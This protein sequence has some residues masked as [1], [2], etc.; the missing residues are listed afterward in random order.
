MYSLISNGLGAHRLIYS[1]ASCSHLRPSPGAKGHSR[2]PLSQ[3]H[4][5]GV[6]S[7]VLAHI[8]IYPRCPTLT[9]TAAR[10]ILAWIKRAVSAHCLLRHSAN[11]S[12]TTFRIMAST[13]S[14]VGHGLAKGLGI[15]LEYR[16]TDKV[17]RGE[18]TFSVESADSYIEQEPTAAEWLRDI[19]PTGRT[20]LRYLRSLF[21]FTHWITR[22]NLQWFA[23]D[24][25]A[26]Q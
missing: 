10:S 6:P 16:E 18:S 3:K 4:V 21:P 12:H 11:Y 13:S 17:T 1:G 25:V 15:K 22:Y 8:P 14:K 26:G 23:G 5:G 9:H 24:L 19:T 20:M 2:S 7:A